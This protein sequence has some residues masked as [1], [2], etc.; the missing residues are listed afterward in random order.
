S[1]ETLICHVE[2]SCE[3]WL[4]QHGSLVVLWLRFH[5]EEEIILVIATKDSTMKFVMNL[6]GN[7]D[8]VAASPLIM[9]TPLLES[10]ED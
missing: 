7:S 3:R 10:G 6:L 9:S 2:R 4:Q 8:L 1:Y 5:V